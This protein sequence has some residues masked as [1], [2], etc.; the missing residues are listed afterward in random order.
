MSEN[1]IFVL[2]MKK[3]FFYFIL[4]ITLSVIAPQFSNAQCAMCQRN[5]ETS[6]KAGNTT[7]KGL[8]TGILYIMM[9]PYA[10]IGGIGYWWYKNYRKSQGTE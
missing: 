5:A 4:F 6:L 10:L 2:V 3:A 9:V 1:R 7:A 8:D